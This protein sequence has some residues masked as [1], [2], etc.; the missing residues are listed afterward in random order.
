MRACAAGAAAAP[1]GTGLNIG[2][3]DGLREEIIG[4]VGGR[5]LRG[6]GIFSPQA[7]AMA[8]AAVALGEHGGDHG[9]G[10]GHGE[11]K[12]LLVES[13]FVSECQQF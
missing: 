10:S 7:M 2:A 9:G 5:A 6:R 3:V 8:A 4:S 12:R 1:F 13:Q 11:S